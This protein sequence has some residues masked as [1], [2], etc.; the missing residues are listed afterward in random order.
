MG[1]EHWLATSAIIV[2]VSL[3]ANRW[4]NLR[5]CSKHVPLAVDPRC[6]DALAVHE[7]VWNWTIIFLETV[8]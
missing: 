6:L 4:C 8:M 2:L 3:P 7:I 1:S 5:R